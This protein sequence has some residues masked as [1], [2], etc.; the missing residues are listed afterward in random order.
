L[1]QFKY[2]KESSFIQMMVI[3]QRDLKLPALN[4]LFKANLST[5]YFNEKPRNG[6]LKGRVAIEISAS[7]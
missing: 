5:K 7:K 1:D 6:I 3:R 4:I 2:N